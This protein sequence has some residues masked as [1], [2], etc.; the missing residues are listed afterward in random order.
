MQISPL[1]AEHCSCHQGKALGHLGRDSGQKDP[2]P[3]AL[4][5]C[6][7]K[8]MMMYETAMPLESRE[9]MTDGIIWEENPV[10]VMETDGLGLSSWHCWGWSWAADSR[11]TSL[12]G[13]FS[14]SATLP[15]VVAFNQGGGNGRNTWK[16][17]GRGVTWQPQSLLGFDMHVCQEWQF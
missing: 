14:M 11:G 6:A 8:M 2:F 4:H 7:E 1:V 12:G 10:S 16:G 3:G 15:S 17:C 5:L 9:D 13:R